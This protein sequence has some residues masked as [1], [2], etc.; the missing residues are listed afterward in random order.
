MV[1]KLDVRDKW[2]GRGMKSLRAIVDQ[3]VFEHQGKVPAAIIIAAWMQVYLSNGLG[4]PWK[5]FRGIP[6]ELE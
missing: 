4:G 1:Y 5:T 6:L 3:C 2:D